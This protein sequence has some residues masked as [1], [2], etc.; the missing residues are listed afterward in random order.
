MTVKLSI[1][2]LTSFLSVLHA[3]CCQGKPGAIL[4]TIIGR[5]DPLRLISIVHDEDAKKYVF[6]QTFNSH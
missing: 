4:M 1:R 2:T 6:L 5:T 3:E